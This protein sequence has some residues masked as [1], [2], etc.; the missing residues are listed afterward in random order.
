MP[1]NPVKWLYK[2]TGNKKLY[3]LA[4]IILQA[5]SGASGVL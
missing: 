2:V 1:N 3:I 4:L 5:L